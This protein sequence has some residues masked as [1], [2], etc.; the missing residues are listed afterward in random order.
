[1]AVTWKKVGFYSTLLTVEEQEIVGRLT[2]GDLDG[3]AIGI[4]DNNMVQVDGSPNA[5]EV[6]Y[7]TAN[8]LKGFA[9]VGSTFPALPVDGMM[10]CHEVT[11]RKILYCYDLDNT[12]W[13]PIISIGEMTLYVDK[14][15]GSDSLEDHGTGV[16]GN[17]FQTIQYA[18]D[19]IPGLYGGD[20]T[21]T[22]N[23][24]VYSENIVVRGKKSTGDYDITITGTWSDT[25]AAQTASG[26]TAGTAN[27][28]TQATVVK[29]GAGWTVNAYIGKWVRFADDTTTTALRGD[30][31]IIESNTSDT[32]SLVG[33][34][35]AAPANGD[36]FSIS[37][38]GT[39]IGDGA[40]DCI[41]ITSQQ[42][43]VVIEVFKTNSQNVRITYQ[44]AAILNY[45]ESTGV[46]ISEL[47]RATLNQ[48]YINTTGNGVS[49]YRLSFATIKG[50][51]IKGDGGASNYG[52]IAYDNAMIRQASIATIIDNFGVG[53]GVG[54]AAAGGYFS[55]Y[56]A[57]VP[58]HVV[59]NCTV[60]M[61]AQFLS[62][63]TPISATNISFDTCGT[64]TADDAA[65]SAHIVA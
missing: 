12:T 44:S 13:I 7:W 65:T 9:T 58:N 59:R 18:I 41:D 26:G 17:A 61:K 54:I 2:G 30:I 53:V 1:M 32:L 50:N 11:G 3:I 35:D 19:T 23:A 64:D 16:D 25:L 51:L 29:S 4:A 27:S 31:R 36:T 28:A 57:T 15:D 37:Y 14:T 47:S 56:L 5:N 63:A 34:L 22:V 52:V 42:S 43:D 24:E 10:F 21:I 33:G 45:M 48:L 8:G 49:C 62:L 20:V 6:A 39:T 46:A 38:P 60:G 40:G 55:C